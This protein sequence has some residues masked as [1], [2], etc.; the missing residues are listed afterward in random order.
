MNLSD[1]KKE[2]QKYQY[3]E[4]TQIIDVALASIIA[5]RLRFGRPI[6]LIVIGAS[7]GGKSQ[8]LR[9]LSITDS[10]FLH[11]VD[12][13]TENTFLSGIRAKEDEPISLLLR[14]GHHGMIV[15]S[16]F[17]VIM[18]KP[19]ESRST[20]LS[21]FR[22]IYDG[23]MTKHSGTSKNAITW[24]GHG[25]K[26][27]HLGVLAGSTPSIYS[28]MEQ[29][30]DMGERFIYYRMKDY[31]PEKATHLAMSRKVDENNLDDILATL[32]GDYI[33]DVVLSYNAE[34]SLE[35]DEKTKERIIEISA[36]AER[37]R[38]TAEFDRYEKIITKIP[39]PAFPMR[40]ALQLSAI[41]KG[42]L[43]IRK[44]ETGEYKLTEDDLSSLDWVAYSLANEE[45]RACLKVLASVAFESPMTTSTISDQIGLDTK[46][47]RIVL[48]NLASVG[49]LKRD[50]SS[51]STALKWSFKNRNDYEIVRRIEHIKNTSIIENR[52][53][54][55]EEEVEQL[56]DRLAENW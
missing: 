47:V 8:I 53:V 42:L 45:K 6:W 11:R 46:I 36:F 28:H 18:S 16:D 50:G 3:F 17:T 19:S 20:I 29:V 24:P 44:H 48:Q 22:M 2:I 7:S 27:G 4:D 39:V 31:N 26:K 49:V 56:D 10:K 21:Q 35:L 32:Y 54:S 30:S 37:V 40:V 9:P 1:L 34:D 41:A 25:H 51:D 38:T 52:D 12:D 43:V 23:E 55:D 33:K 15:I 13:V 5:N 14:I